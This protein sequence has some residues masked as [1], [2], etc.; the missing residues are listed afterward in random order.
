[1]RSLSNISKPDTLF[2]PL[3]KPTFARLVLLTTRRSQS[4]A[5][6]LDKLSET[7]QSE[8]ENEKVVVN[9]LASTS[10]A[11]SGEEGP[12]MKTPPPDPTPG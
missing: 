5:S 1:M 11:P 12:V 9:A 3:S 10:Q 4:T 7:L 2:S 8:V 6:L